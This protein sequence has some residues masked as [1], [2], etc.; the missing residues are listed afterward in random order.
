[1]RPLEKLHRIPLKIKI[2]QILK[3][4]GYPKCENFLEKLSVFN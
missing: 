1:M 3:K 4:C 2:C